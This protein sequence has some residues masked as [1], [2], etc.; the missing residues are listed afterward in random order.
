VASYEL[1]L[2]RNGAPL[3]RLT[4]E[5]PDDFDALH[6]AKAFSRDYVVEVYEG[7]R[8]V[9]RVKEREANAS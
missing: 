7:I 6:R 2:I 8:L 5:C 1:F 4:Q 9:G 3:E